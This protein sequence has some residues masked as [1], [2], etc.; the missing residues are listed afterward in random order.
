M[1]KLDLD[2]VIPKK[3]KIGN[4]TITVEFN[5]FSED[6]QLTGI[7]AM[8]FYDPNN[9]KIVIN[10]ILREN[11]PTQII[12]TFWHEVIH[13]INHSIRFHMELQEEMNDKDTIEDDAWKF[14]EKI[15]EN[16]ARTFLQVIQDN[17]LLPIA[18]VK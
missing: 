11:N 13:A 18:E 8:G 14:E 17:N 12:E 1:A 15:T 9:F 16:F 2:K 5:D 10:S 6:D 3:I 7:G 4:R